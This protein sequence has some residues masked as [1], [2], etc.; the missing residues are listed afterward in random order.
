MK[1]RII[2]SGYEPNMNGSGS[3][4][5]SV[6][7]Y[8]TFNIPWNATWREMLN[9]SCNVLY[10]RH[11]TK[12]F[13]N[14][15]RTQDYYEQTSSAY[16][17]TEVKEYPSAEYSKRV[18]LRLQRNET[19]VGYVVDGYVYCFTDPVKNAPVGLDTVINTSYEWR[20]S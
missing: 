16:K 12:T 14:G 1:T 20:L 5:I 17:V 3:I 13:T 8:A 10:S 6:D 4:R 19:G 9:L 11:I 2:S 18:Y 7:S 15:D